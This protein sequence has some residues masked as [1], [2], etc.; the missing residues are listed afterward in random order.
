MILIKLCQFG[1]LLHCVVQT[2]KFVNQLNLDSI[3]SQPYAALSNLMNL[4][5]FD[6]ATF[7]NHIQEALISAVDVGLKLCHDILG[8]LTH[9]KLGLVSGKLVCLHTVEGYTKLI[10]NESAEVWNQSE[11]SDTTSDGSRLGKDIVGRRADPVSTRCSSTT[12]RYHYRL[13]GLNQFEC[14][15]NLL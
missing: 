1:S 10:G 4:L 7:R 6:T 5:G 8:V 15:A 2:S 14:M 3:G 9:N 11:D 12:H 13:L